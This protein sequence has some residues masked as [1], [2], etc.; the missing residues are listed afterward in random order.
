MT[1]PP[2]GAPNAGAPGPN[3]YERGPQPTAPGPSPQPTKKVSAGRIAVIAGVAVVLLVGSP[4][5]FMAG[6]ASAAG[7]TTGTSPAPASQATTAPKVPKAS[8]SPTTETVCAGGT[9]T[10][11]VWSAKAP[12]GWQCSGPQALGLSL[13]NPTKDTITLLVTPAPDDS[14]CDSALSIFAKLVKL[15]DVAWGG[16]TAIAAERDLSG[17]VLS[18]RCTIRDGRMY[19]MTATPITGTSD[20]VRTALDALVASWT[21]K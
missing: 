10:G 6:R 17:A 12:A 18:Y 19:L 9:L 5:A 14:A 1:Q 4:L 13:A 2:Y 15:P 8:A 16:Q 7:T 20:S 11:A 3:P 21:W